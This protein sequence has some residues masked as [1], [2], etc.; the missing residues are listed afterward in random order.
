M[1]QHLRG[2][3]G[4][5]GRHPGRTSRPALGR[6]RGLVSAGDRLPVPGERGRCRLLAARMTDG[7]RDHLRLDERVETEPL[8]VSRAAPSADRTAPETAR[9]HA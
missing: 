8:A 3:L 9:G 4:P 1:G 2:K 6:E 5:A 7:V